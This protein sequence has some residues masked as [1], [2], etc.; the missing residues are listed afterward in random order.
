MVYY[1]L[2]E[3]SLYTWSGMSHLGLAFFLILRPFIPEFDMCTDL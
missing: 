2:V 1:I 3:V